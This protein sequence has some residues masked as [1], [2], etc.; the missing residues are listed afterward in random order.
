[1]F[2]VRGDSGAFDHTV[3]ARAESAPCAR[4][5]FRHGTR[6]RADEFLANTLPNDLPENTIEGRKLL[7]PLGQLRVIVIEL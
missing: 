2:E 3:A 4:R 6:A 5:E 1:V 7:N